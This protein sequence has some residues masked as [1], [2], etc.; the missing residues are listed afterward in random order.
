MTSAS[1]SSELR[2]APQQF[3]HIRRT[4]D[5]RAGCA[6]ARIQPGEIYVAHGN[7]RIATVLGSCVSACIYDAESGVGGMNHFL[8]PSGPA[9]TRSTD[10]QY[11]E[12][13]MKR[14]IWELVASG[15]ARHNL[16][17]KVFGGA[18]IMS[19]LNDVGAQNAEFVRSYLASENI[20]IV[21]EDLG[22]EHP[23]K[24]IM[25][26]DTGKIMVRRLRTLVHNSV[27]QREGAMLPTE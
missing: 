10:A 2:P 1:Q 11:G 14:L 16:K 8:M 23:R 18:S 6:V 26:V 20:D 27:A 25:Q 22:D 9:S 4:W 21:A 24:I 5:E 19:S 7:E 17:A 13:A 3:K 12:Q 15:A